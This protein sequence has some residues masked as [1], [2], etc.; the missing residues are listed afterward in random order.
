M[1]NGKVPLIIGSDARAYGPAI[2]RG[3]LELYH[4]A[5]TPFIDFHANSGT[6]AEDYDA[7]LI[8]STPDKLSVQGADMEIE[9]REVV[10]SLNDQPRCLLQAYHT[11]V[12]SDGAGNFT[13]NY[14]YG[15]FPNG[16]WFSNCVISHQGNNILF[17]RYAGD[18]ISSSWNMKDA[19][20]GGA[21]AN[22]VVGV[23][24]IAVGY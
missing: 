1:L 3:G 10:T 7:R 17:S 18:R 4:E 19:A 21:L 15:S 9:G 16:L 5:N 6:G 23:D 8:L 11:F 22:V 14:G 20:T 13:H 12:G 2:S 24:I